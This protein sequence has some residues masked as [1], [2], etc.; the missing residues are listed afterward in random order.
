LVDNLLPIL[1]E[2]DGKEIK[3][4]QSLI[5]LL[6]AGK[7]KELSLLLESRYK[8]YRDTELDLTM[9]LGEFMTICQRIRSDIREGSK[10]RL[11]K[12]IRQAQAD[13]D[14]ERLTQLFQELQNLL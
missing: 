2:L 9:A 4:D 8:I 14:S 1:I 11:A 13:N 5:N 3:P 10:A 6:P 7:Q 12:D